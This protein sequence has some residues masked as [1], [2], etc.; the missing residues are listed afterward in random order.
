MLLDQLLEADLEEECPNEDN[1]TLPN[2]PVALQDDQQNLQRTLSSL[3]VGNEIT[4]EIS[5]LLQQGVTASGNG[6]VQDDEVEEPVSAKPACITAKALLELAELAAFV[7]QQEDDYH[8]CLNRVARLVPFFHEFVVVVRKE[9]GFL[10]KAQL[11]GGGQMNFHNFLVHEL[12]KARLSYQLSATRQ[13]RFAVWSTFASLCLDKVKNKCSGPSSSAS[14]D[15]FAQLPKSYKPCST[16]KPDGSGKRDYQLLAFRSH[17][18]S[19]LKIGLVL[20]VFRGAVKQKEEGATRRQAACKISADALPSNS[21]AKLHVIPLMPLKYTAFE[22]TCMSPVCIID[23]HDASGLVC[24]E[25]PSNQF[26]TSETRTSAVFHLNSGVVKALNS[27][28]HD[29]PDISG[30]FPDLQTQPIKVSYSIPRGG[31]TAESFSLSNHGKSAISAY[32]EVTRGIFEET[33]G[34][35]LVDNDGRVRFVKGR[36]LALICLSVQIIKIQVKCAYFFKGFLY[37]LN[38]ATLIPHFGSQVST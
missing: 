16:L 35:N 9:E 11:D 26:S 14:S 38:V 4:H 33:H 13:S 6:S 37:F 19:S 8:M 30:E 15:L 5:E 32:V 2:D 24:F 22:A 20:S 23:P 18:T 17:L 25:V 27:L 12:A 34:T 21:C 28:K 29:M 3:A 7:P 36:S 31:F 1:E 10:S